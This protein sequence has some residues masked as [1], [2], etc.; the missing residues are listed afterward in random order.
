MSFEMFLKLINVH[1]VSNAYK[2]IQSSLATG[3]DQY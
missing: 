3:P 1:N 2:N